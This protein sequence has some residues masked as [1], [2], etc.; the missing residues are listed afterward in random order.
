LE[1]CFSNIALHADFFRFFYLGDCGTGVS[2][3]EEKFWVDVATG[4][5]MAPIHIH[6]RRHL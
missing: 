3:W 4:S 2:N 1:A 5:A 6:F